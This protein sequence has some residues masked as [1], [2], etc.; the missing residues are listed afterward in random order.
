MT[1]GS[2][3]YRRV[4]AADVILGV[5]DLLMIQLVNKLLVG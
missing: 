5:T 2:R 3:T 4:W 1:Y